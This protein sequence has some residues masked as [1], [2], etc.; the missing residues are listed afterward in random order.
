TRSTTPLALHVALPIFPATSDAD[1]AQYLGRTPDEVPH[2]R[3][4]L[5]DRAP[6]VPEHAERQ[7]AQGPADGARV[8][9]TE[10]HRVHGDDAPRVLPDH[11]PLPQPGGARRGRSLRLP[12]HRTVPIPL[13]RPSVRT[14]GASGEVIVFAG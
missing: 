3:A 13:S 11:H 14:V 5:P 10:G 12:D 8:L 9:P 6:P 2:G 4:Q 1:V 7:P